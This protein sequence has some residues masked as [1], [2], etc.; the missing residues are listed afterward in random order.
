MALK[1]FQTQ[2]GV[3]IS[4]TPGSIQIDNRTMQA[5]DSLTVT[6]GNAEYFAIV[7]R[8]NNQ[9]NGVESSAVVYDSAH[10]MITLHISELYNPT[11]DNSDNILIISKFDPL[12][13]LLWQKQLAADVKV[14][15]V[16]DVC[17][18][19]DDNIIVA[20]SVGNA[21]GIDSIVL[22]KLDAAGT[23]LWQKD[24]QGAVLV[25]IIISSLSLQS[26]TVTSTTYQGVPAQSITLA[27]VYARILPGWVFES[28]SDGS[29]YTPVGTVL[30]V[31]F[32][33]VDNL[34]TLYFPATP[35]IT[36]DSQTLTYS[37]S[38]EGPNSFQEL[39]AVQCDATH[40]YM[41]G[42][43]VENTDEGQSESLIMKVSLADG[44]LTWAQKF[45]FG[46]TT[47]L[48][49]MDLGPNNTLVVVGVAV[50]GFAPNAAYASK[51]NTVDGSAV[52]TKIL[53]NPED[54]VSYSGADV[55]VDTQGNVIMSFNS[56]QAIVHEN[57]NDTYV[58]ISHLI[59][60]TSAGENL[61]VR[62]IGPGPCAS[63]STGIDSDSLGNVYLS[64]LTVVQDNPVR[65][66]DNFFNSRNV[67][68]VAKFNSSGVPVWQRYVQAPGYEF[69]PS[70]DEGGFPGF[71]YDYIHNR[72]RYLSVTD[73]GKLAVQVTV[74]QIDTDDN[75]PDNR[76][77]ESVTLQMDQD[78]RTLTLGSGNEMFTITESRIP[79]KFITVSE[80]TTDELVPTDI[81]N[82]IAVTTTTKILEEGVLAQQIARSA[83]YDYVFGND[84]TVTV[85][86]D[87][88]IKLTQ[89]QIGWFSIFGPAN[90]NNNDIWIRASCVDSTTHDVY[91]VGEDNN[92]NQGF[93]ARYNSE[94]EIL[95]SVRLYDQDN[96]NSTRCNAVKITPNS[97]NV[98]VLSEYYGNETGA[99]MVEI[100]PDT[101][102]VINSQGF[103]D[104]DENN[105]VNAYD[106]GFFSDGNMVV[107]GRKYDEYFT[108]TVTPQ[109]GST[110]NT[111]IVLNAAI[112]AGSHVSP[113][114]TDWTVTGTG[115]TGRASITDINRYNGISGTTTQGSGAQFSIVDNGDGTYGAGGVDA[116]GV[117]YQVGHKILIPG[118]SL[119]GTTPTNDCVVT[120]QSVEGTGVLSINVSGTAAGVAPITYTTVSGTNYQVGAGFQIDF[121]YDSAYAGAGAT[122]VTGG[123]NYVQGDVITVLG[124]SLGGT[125]PTNDLT[126]TVTS[127][128]GSGDINGFDFSGTAQTT[129]RKLTVNQAVDFGGAGTWSVGYDLGGEAFVWSNSWTKV[130]SAGGQYDNERYLS[131]AVDVNDNV[132]AAGEMISRDGAAGPDLNDIWC[133]VV[134]KFNSSGTHQWTKALN[135]N[136][137]NCYAKG[138]TVTGAVVAVTFENSGNG[139]TVVTKL[140]TAGTIKWQ[141]RTGSND[142]SSVA[143][144]SNGDIYV[145]TEYNFDNKYEDVI[146]VIRLAANGEPIWRKFV[147]TLSYEYGGTNER[148]KNGRNLT[149]D[150]TSLYVSGY[151]STFANDYESGFLFK[152]P[153][154]GDCDG[155][156]G[157]WTVQAEMYDVS[158]VGPTEAT[159]FTPVINTGNFELWEPNFATNWWDASDNNYYHTLQEIRDRDGGAIEFADGT[160]QTSSAQI[161]PQ[162]RISNGADHRLTTEDA[163]KHIY[164]TDSN[165]SIIV[166]Y[167]EDNPLPIG[168]TVVIVNYSGSSINVDAD[169]GGLTIIVPGSGSNQYW[170][171]DNEGMTTLL[172]VDA[173]IWFMT[174]NVTQD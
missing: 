152:L 2:D 16:H 5:G 112:A 132:Y 120:V 75:W 37:V 47:L 135:N 68:A 10:N 109:T 44:S 17:I 84:G 127:V 163:G 67:L 138:V 46:T 105:S 49:G 145:V 79:G 82:S 42:E 57:N 22:L 48:Y 157:V 137:N 113:V 96:G 27:N 36:L 108:L 73:S 126:V 140:D 136:T 141:R 56:Q 40:I 160:R 62:R 50:P 30:G 74:A 70:K 168:F 115:I 92:N 13:Q 34:T 174:G 35:S 59:K 90:N 33:T 165:T 158:T 12:A 139:D 150:D 7:N 80:F 143:I 119:G 24:Y 19:L 53:F 23:I 149:I 41:G 170:D 110:T 148:F 101:A 147:G 72:G 76:Y 146:K 77:W 122:N 66:M 21:D 93:V 166:P 86:N 25:P 88:D 91:V 1:Q 161:I 142:D 156:Y 106:F 116:A 54:D 167:H 85:P 107:V 18:D 83:S 111:L 114:Q 11:T 129:I 52:W 151:T 102:E 65:D 64:A 144:D 131:V 87:G 124:T 171:L 154:S 118:T 123:T 39:G 89:T 8:A 32:N 43:Y 173:G 4:N 29:N 133:A 100:D 28:S 45:N 20:T 130:L 98:M 172:K 162:V 51:F 58:S 81:T 3:R 6:T 78:G 121:L 128:G 14:N 164:V 125:S 26:D 9:D 155:Y 95:W 117:N 104:Q 97:K 159:T 69:I 15:L 31:Q 99:L 94:G 103:R 134:S 71:G 60:I 38:G 55:T 61:W 63:V 153:K 169:G